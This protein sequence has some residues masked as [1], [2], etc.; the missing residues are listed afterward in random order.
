MTKEWLAFKAVWTRLWQE[1]IKTTAYSCS[2]RGITY[3]PEACVAAR[4]RLDRLLEVRPL[5][6][7]DL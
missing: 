5:T 4:A 6:P 2:T 7:L 3:D 1:F